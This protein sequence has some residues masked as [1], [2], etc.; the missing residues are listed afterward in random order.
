M[1]MR[2]LVVRGLVK[3]VEEDLNKFLATH[4]VNVLHMAQSEHGEY[5]SMTLIYEEPR[6]LT[7]A[8]S[9]TAR[10]DDAIRIENARAHNLKGVSC[11]DPASGRSPW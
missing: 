4:Q 10:R 9:G 5:I 1:A 2:C 3:E 11:R 6:R 8:R 7:R